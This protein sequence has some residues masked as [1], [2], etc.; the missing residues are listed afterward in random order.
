MSQL[1]TRLLFFEAPATTNAREGESI[2]PQQ[3]FLKRQS[4]NAKKG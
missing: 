2:P 3:R 1:G 4:G